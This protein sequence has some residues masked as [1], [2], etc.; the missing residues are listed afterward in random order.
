MFISHLILS[1]LPCL[2]SHNLPTHLSHNQPSHLFLLSLLFISYQPWSNFHLIYYLMRLLVR[3][4]MMRWFM[5]WDEM[6][7]II[8]HFS[9]H[10][11]SINMIDGRVVR[12]MREE[13]VSLCRWEMREKELGEYIFHHLIWSFTYFHHFFLIYHLMIYHLQ[14]QNHKLSHKIVRWEMSWLVWWIASI[15]QISFWG[16]LLIDDVMFGHKMRWW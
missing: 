15:I 13:L 1:H 2:S 12:W 8:S 16:L 9:S 11:F 14:S 10:F 7:E 3:V 6:V 4:K 5:I